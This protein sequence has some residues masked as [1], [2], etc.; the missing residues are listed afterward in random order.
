MIPKLTDDAVGR[1]PLEGGRSAL[2]EEI[3]RDAPV[4]ESSRPRRWLAP[5]VAAAMVAGIA[6]GTVAWS[7]L[8]GEPGHAPVSGQLS[9]PDGQGLVL[10]APGWR[11]TALGTDGLVF[12]K[13][14]ASLEISSYAA[15]QYD[16]YV[17]DREH[18]DD[19]PKDGRPITV[20]GRPALMWAYS[21]TDHTAIREVQ[22]GHWLELRAAGMDGDAYLALLGQ[23]RF[24]TQA[25]FEAS[26]PNG[27]VTA[28]ARPAAAA[29]ILREVEYVS[30]AGFP[31]GVEVPS[32]ADGDAV[33][34]YQ[35]G[36]EVA[37]AYAC[38]WFDAFA[39]ATDH[40]QD[41][42]ALEAARVL[43]TA[44]LWPVLIQ[45]D[46]EGG[47]PEVLWELTDLVAAGVV[48]DWYREGLGC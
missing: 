18:I 41:A 3:V 8:R 13:V 23:L 1:L 32:F 17:T 27:Y 22:D 38:A 31:T 7:E 36:V 19:V 48:P 37:G 46:D 26:L 43:G 10:D 30:G 14:G 25:E 6:V 4:A 21:A 40:Q 42:Q 15:D 35:F 16:S 20:L 11:I 33:D 2:L 9:L 12:G 5:L 44:R 29:K 45:M 28:Q 24:T 39:N 34:G 47:Y